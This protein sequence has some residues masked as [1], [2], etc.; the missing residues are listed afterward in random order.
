MS[1]RW[2]LRI[3][4][5]SIISSRNSCFAECGRIYWQSLYEPVKI[6]SVGILDHPHIK[7]AVLH[8]EY[9]GA[10]ARKYPFASELIY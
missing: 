3:D 4:Y 7:L 8:F 5:D 1:N 10:Q 9:S 6:S 2:K